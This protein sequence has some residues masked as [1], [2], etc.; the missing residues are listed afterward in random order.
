V[1]AVDFVLVGLTGTAFM[2]LVAA[3]LIACLAPK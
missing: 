1:T 2:L 3:C